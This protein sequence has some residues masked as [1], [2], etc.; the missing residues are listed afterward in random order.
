MRLFRDSPAAYQPTPFG[1]S[2]W[3]S[4]HLAGSPAYTR[5]EEHALGP[6][7]LRINCPDSDN[8]H[9]DTAYVRVLDPP[10]LL[11]PVQ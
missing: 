3:F 6:L 10:V 4:P 1:G 9:L 8:A 2:G 7:R 5:A 11:D